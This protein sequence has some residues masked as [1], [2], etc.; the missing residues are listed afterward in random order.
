MTDLI[1][2]VYQALSNLK[3]SDI[4]VYD[5]R[6]VSPYYDY[7]VLASAS[8]ERQVNAA[9]NHIKQALP[10]G[11]DFHIEGQETSRWILIDLHEVIIHV[12][13]KEDREFYQIEKIFYERDTLDLEVSH[14]L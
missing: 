13:H 9:I 5:F 2:T 6:G 12:M 3:L 11:T 1:H 7:Q 10:E 14:G 4:V 8:N